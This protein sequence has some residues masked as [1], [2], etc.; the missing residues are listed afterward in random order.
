M[1]APN[2][3]LNRLKNGRHLRPLKIGELPKPLERVTRDAR[4]YRRYLETRVEQEHGRLNDE[5]HH[6]IDEACANEVHAA[7]CRW[8]LRTKIETMSAADIL[9]CSRDIP[10]VK[11]E[12]NRAVERLKLCEPFDPWK[13]I[14]AAVVTDAND[15][16]G[17]DGE[18]S[19][20]PTSSVDSSA[21]MGHNATAGVVGD[22]AGDSREGDQ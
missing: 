3:N 18:R 9:A 11:R 7:V 2:N 20:V 12:R 10:K 4:R 17:H 6:L 15:T 21:G 1:G 16:A 13:A 14:D 22:D 8:L 19:D 5:H